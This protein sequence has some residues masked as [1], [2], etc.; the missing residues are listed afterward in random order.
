MTKVVEKK[1]QGLTTNEVKIEIPSTDQLGSLKT[2]ETG[3]NMNPKYRTKEDWIE[4]KEK[5]VRAYFLGLRELPN[6]DGDAV[7]CGVFSTEKEIFFAGQKVLI[8]AVRSLEPKTPVSITFKET[9]KNKSSQ[10]STMIFEVKLL[11]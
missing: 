9:R 7:L 5:E 4:L 8:D 11:K 1:E 2:M 10:G 6:D 3:F